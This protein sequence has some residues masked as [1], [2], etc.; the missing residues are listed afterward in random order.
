[1]LLLDKSKEEKRRNNQ[2]KK[3]GKC[4]PNVSNMPVDSSNFNKSWRSLIIA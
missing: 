4:E 3:L 1:M 2:E